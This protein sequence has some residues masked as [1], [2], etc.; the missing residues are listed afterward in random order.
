MNKAEKRINQKIY[1]QCEC[2]TLLGEITIVACHSVTFSG[3]LNSRGSTFP[4]LSWNLFSGFE[5]LIALLHTS[6]RFFSNWS[7]FWCSFWHHLLQMGRSTSDGRFVAVCVGKKRLYRIGNA[8]IVQYSSVYSL[9][10]AYSFDF[11]QVM[12]RSFG[13]SE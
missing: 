6:E 5:D 4:R 3:Y 7:K 10:F 9:V 11:F 1:Q 13:L 12:T 8:D 2:D